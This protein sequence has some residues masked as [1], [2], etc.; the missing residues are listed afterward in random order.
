[1]AGL[2]M[3]AGLILLYLVVTGRAAKMVHAILGT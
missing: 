2:M 3:L 1:M